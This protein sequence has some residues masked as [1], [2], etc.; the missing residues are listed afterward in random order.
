M[1][2]VKPDV[3]HL[4]KFGAVAY[5]HVP[6]TPGHRKHE[7]NAKLGYVLGYA[8]EVMG[9]KVFFPDERTAKVVPDLRVAED[10]VY[11]DRHDVFPE[12]ID[13]ESLHFSEPA[14]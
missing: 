2:G 1:F 14:R 3:H 12:D 8:E 6:V 10:V 9:C 13:L 5:V 4:R 7:D 11:R